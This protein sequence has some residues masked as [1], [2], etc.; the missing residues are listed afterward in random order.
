MGPQD[1]LEIQGL[2]KLVPNIHFVESDLPSALASYLDTVPKGAGPSALKEK[3]LELQDL[4]VTINAGESQRVVAFR[5]G[6]LREFPG[7]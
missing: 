2:R 1:G 7:T 6:E 4:A 5:A 3:V